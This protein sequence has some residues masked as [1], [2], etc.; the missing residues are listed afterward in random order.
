MTYTLEAA[1][2]MFADEVNKNTL[3]TINSM[4]N[5]DYKTPYHIVI[6]LKS[7]IID[8]TEMERTVYE[9]MLNHKYV[10]A[11]Y[12]NENVDM[13]NG[14]NYGTIHSQADY[15]CYVQ[16]GDIQHTDRLST[17]V[18][19]LKLHNQNVGVFSGYMENENFNQYI[20]HAI[21]KYEAYSAP[22][23]HFGTLAINTKLIPDIDNNFVFEPYWEGSFLH[24]FLIY[25]SVHNMII[26]TEPSILVDIESH[27][28][29]ETSF[30]NNKTENILK[31]SSLPS[32]QD[33]LLTIIIPFKNEGI[34][35][36]KTVVSIR[37]TSRRFM[38]I[39][40]LNDTSDDEYDY[41]LIAK[42]YGCLYYRNPENLGVA[43]SRDFAIFNLIKTEYFMILDAHMRF[44]ENNWDD[45]ILTLAQEHPN[46]IICS[47]TIEMTRDKDFYYNENGKR[48]IRGTVGAWLNELPM[49]GCYWNNKDLYVKGNL[50]SIPCVLGACYVSSKEHWKKIGGLKFLRKYGLDEQLMSIKNFMYGGQN[51]YLMDFHTGHFYKINEGQNTLAPVAN[52]IEVNRLLMTYL[53]NPDNLENHLNKIKE[54]NKDNYEKIYDLFRSNINDVDIYKQKLLAEAKYTFDDFVKFN[55]DFK[56]AMNDKTILII[57]CW[58]G[59]DVDYYLQRGFKVI[60]FEA[61]QNLYV[62]LRKKFKDFIDRGNLILR[63]E[64]VWKKSGQLIPFYIEPD[65]PNWSSIDNNIVHRVIENEED[66]IHTYVHTITIDDIIKEYGMPDLCRISVS[67]GELEIL[68]GINKNNKPIYLTTES[69]FLGKDPLR[70]DEE[71]AILRKLP[72]LGYKKFHLY[73]NHNTFDFGE[74]IEEDKFAWVNNKAMEEIISLD[75]K[76]FFEQNK[77][78]PHYCYYNSLHCSV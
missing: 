61:N 24:R 31:L 69:E 51:L 46:D 39:L 55:N 38:N 58:E 76:H 44:D 20:Y 54:S 68:D 66:I 28:D 72:K 73:D 4:L 52:E 9:K 62:N 78:L 16:N 41:E 8:L 35:V 36:E 64:C 65:H 15:V 71:F 47:S 7:P 49:W 14:L 2:V 6:V 42:E 63:N 37:A 18:K 59:T 57:G 40:L 67:G 30:L 23:Y 77:D 11:L 34:E 26:S 48:K 53:F 17:Q 27:T 5:Q 1:F 10:T 21:T 70:K 45:R 13:V 25:L 32:E 12:V 43:G 75:R 56:Y 29:A 22:L 50:V 60:A 33:K 3:K 19:Y 74:L